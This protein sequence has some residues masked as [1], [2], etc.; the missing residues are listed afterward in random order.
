MPPSSLTAGWVGQQ[1]DKATRDEQSH[2]VVKPKRRR[3][4]SREATRHQWHTGTG[5]AGEPRTSAPRAEDARARRARQPPVLGW[6]G[7]GLRPPRRSR[8]EPTGRSLSCQPRVRQALRP[9]DDD[10]VP[11][12]LPRPRSGRDFFLASMVPPGP[13][14]S[15]GGSHS[16]ITG[17]GHG[18]RCRSA[19][20]GRPGSKAARRS[21][22]C[23]LVTRVARQAPGGIPA[24]WSAAAVTLS[25]L[26]DAGDELQYRKKSRTVEYC[27][28]SAVLLLY[29]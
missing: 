8:V 22:R 18:A 16:L 25:T 23:S 4:P 10:A 17:H 9:W 13:R 26:M 29:W 12:P 28:T 7:G 24:R 3:W 27:T 14:E 1:T 15:C 2:W 20:S 6:G 5:T 11:L 19:Q 21:R